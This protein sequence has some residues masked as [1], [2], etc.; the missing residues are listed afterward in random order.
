M[1]HCHIKATDGVEFWISCKWPAILSSFGLLQVIQNKRPWCSNAEYVTA[2]IFGK[3]EIQKKSR[4]IMEW[5][6]WKE[7]G[8]T[9]GFS[10]WPFCD[11]KR[12][13]QFSIWKDDVHKLLKSYDFAVFKIFFRDGINCCK[14]NF[15]KIFPTLDKLH[16][17]T[18]HTHLFRYII[19]FFNILAIILFVYSV[20]R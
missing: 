2:G 5:S 9:N 18:L 6:S 11:L 10:E 8:F 17:T 12:F 20:S 3:S 13:L 1:Q 14:V 7:R 15:A 16:F 19:H 4:Q